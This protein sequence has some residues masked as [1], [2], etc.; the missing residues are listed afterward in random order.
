MAEM[1]Q[2]F[3]FIPEDLA[4]G[5]KKALELNYRDFQIA[6]ICSSAHPLFDLAYERLWAEFGSHHTVE[7]R[8]VIEQRLAWHPAATIGNHRLRY[9]MI[10]VQQ[11]NQFAAVRDHSAIMAIRRRRAPYTVVHLSHIFI[12]GPWRRIGLAG[13]LRAW[14]LQTARA[15]LASARLPLNSP[16][17]LVAEMEH[18]DSQLPERM[19]RLKAY[20]K[21]GFKKI[22]PSRVNY[23]Q[24]DFRPPT[25]ID[26]SGGPRPLPFALIV[27]RVGREQEEVIRGE[28]VREIAECLYTMYGAGFRAQEMAP[29]W[30]SIDDYPDN[31]AEIAL[32][33]P[34]Q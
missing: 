14:P 15:C 26:N 31:D 16:V 33:E 12:D 7:P 21:A 4:P 22:D 6:R 8:E 17:T 28:E 27:R 30:K 9:E 18:S 24:P 23:F 34:T 32:V 25:E 11:Q 13:W 3:E 10:L 1:E 29:V 20:G 5:D 2:S 19:I